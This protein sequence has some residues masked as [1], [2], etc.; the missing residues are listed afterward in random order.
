MEVDSVKPRTYTACNLFSFE[1]ACFVSVYFV[2][3][4]IFF[5][6]RHKAYSGKEKVNNS[7][8]QDVFKMLPDL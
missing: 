5:S 8:L 2:S 7:V 3:S 1:C 6:P 4:T